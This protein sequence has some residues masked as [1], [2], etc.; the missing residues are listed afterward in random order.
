MK[1]MLDHINK[2][3]AIEAKEKCQ[4]QIDLILKV[5]GI[6][7]KRL[8]GE[9]AFIRDNRDY[10]VHS[11]SETTTIFPSISKLYRILNIS[12]WFLKKIDFIMNNTSYSYKHEKEQISNISK[13]FWSHIK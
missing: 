3:E 12:T 8:G 5:W 2:K 10:L 1:D 4:K 9:Y 6:F 11:M 7:W 13:E